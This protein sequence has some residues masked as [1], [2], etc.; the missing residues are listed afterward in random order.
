MSILGTGP[1]WSRGQRSGA[2]RVCPGGIREGS[3][4]S[5]GCLL[6]KNDAIPGEYRSAG[7]LDLRPACTTSWARSSAGRARESH[8]RGQGFESPRVHQPG[9]LIQC[10]D[11]GDRPA[12]SAKSSSAQGAQLLAAADNRIA[13]APFTRLEPAQSVDRL[14]RSVDGS[15]PPKNPPLATR[16][17]GASSRDSAFRIECCPELVEPLDPPAQSVRKLVLSIPAPRGDHRTHQDAAKVKHVLVRR[18]IVLSHFF[19]GV[20]DVELDWPEAAC[21]EVDKQRPPHGVQQVA[22]MRLTVQQLITATAGPDRCPQATQC[23]AKEFPVGLQKL[24]ALLSVGHYPEGL[25]DSVGEVW[26]PEIYLIQAGMEPGECVRIVGRRD[27]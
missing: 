27:A 11:V 3:T 5:G 12:G 7:I 26:C 14:H 22:R 4:P 10:A 25:G 13:V 1:K 24:W 21:L 9:R 15:E 6:L 20:G 16:P 23:V 2:V 18:W 17:L 19:G 8:S